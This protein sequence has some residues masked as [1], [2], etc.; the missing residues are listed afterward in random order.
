MK[1]HHVNF[2]Y[3]FTVVCILSTQA[4]I[5]IIYLSACVVALVTSLLVK[6]ASYFLACVARIIPFEW[7][8]TVVNYH[9][10][11]ST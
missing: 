8:L 9:F 10:E 1:N 4:C 5:Y 2:L 6:L 7:L 11:P 3:F